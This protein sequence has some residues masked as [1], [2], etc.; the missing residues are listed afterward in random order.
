MRAG[1]RIFA[2]SL[3]DDR[4]KVDEICKT[5]SII[6]SPSTSPAVTYKVSAVSSDGS[7]TRTRLRQRGCLGASRSPHRLMDGSGPR[8]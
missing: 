1:G 4:V 7:G 2:S 5:I 6:R 3:T 8:R